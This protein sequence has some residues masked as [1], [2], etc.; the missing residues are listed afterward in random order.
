MASGSGKST[1]LRVIN[2]LVDPT[3][4]TVRVM[5]RDVTAMDGGALLAFRR[6]AVSMVFQHFGLLPHKSAAENVMFPL[7]VQGLA[8]VDARERA[9]RWLDRVGLAGYADA[10]LHQLSGGMKQRVGLARALVTEAPVL[11]MDEPFAA[12]DPLTRRAMQ[13]ELLALQKSLGKTVVLV[14]HDPAEAL[15][16]ADRVAVLRGGRL[17][18]AAA[19]A[20][21][22]A[23]P[24]D[25]H[26]AAFMS[27]AT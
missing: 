5:G 15:R 6:A 7:R 19:P 11:L 2:R 8:A 4:G 12:L 17:L 3:Q 10:R 16:V 24:A 1:L 9:L 21:L 18:Q 20:E 27:A 22:L 23:N 14:S 25:E 26:V 13:D